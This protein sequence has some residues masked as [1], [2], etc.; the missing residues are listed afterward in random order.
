MTPSQ[1][2]PTQTPIQHAHEVFSDADAA[3]AR[4]EEL[5]AEATDFLLERFNA[6][7]NEGRPAARFR[8][9]YPEVRITTTSH[10]KADS[11]LAFGHVPCPA[12]MPRRS[13]DR[14][15]SAIT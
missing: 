7:L 9:F 11:R 6:T 8:A 5:Y 10:A 12:L 4:L 3:V 14:I 13:H 2:L 15:C 1:L